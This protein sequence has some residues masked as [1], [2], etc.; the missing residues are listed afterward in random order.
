MISANAMQP[1]GPPQEAISARGSKAFVSAFAA[2]NVKK[3][4]REKACG[5]WNSAI[6]SEVVCPILTSKGEERAFSHCTSLCAS[7]NPSPRAPSEWRRR[8][9]RKM[10]CAPVFWLRPNTVNPQGCDRQGRNA[11]VRGSR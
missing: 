7:P 6:L 10:F 4:G 1:S 9:V 5:T 11:L 3:R 2:K 8:D